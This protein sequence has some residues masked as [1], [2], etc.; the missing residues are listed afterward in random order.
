MKCKFDG[1]SRGNPSLDAYGELFHDSSG[2]IMYRFLKF[3]DIATS[4]EAEILIVTKL[5]EVKYQRGR[6]TL[7]LECKFIL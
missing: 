3:V 2:A 7:W 4:L 1:A 5:I 6:Y